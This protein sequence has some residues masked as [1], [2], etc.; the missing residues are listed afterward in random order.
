MNRLWKQAL[1]MPFMLRRLYYSFRLMFSSYFIGGAALAILLVIVTVFIEK[2]QFARATFDTVLLMHTIVLP[3]VT[4]I[5]TANAFAEELEERVFPLVW[6]YPVRKW[7]LFVERASSLLIILTLY[8]AASIFAVHMWLF[9]LTRAQVWDLLR[10]AIPTHV[11]LGGMTLMFSLIGRS[12]LTGL[13]AGG[14]Y[15]FVELITRGQWTK[16]SIFLFEPVWKLG[17]VD[18]IVNRWRVF[19]L[20]LLWFTV[21][22]V[23]FILGRRRLA[24]K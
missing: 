15:W 20:G 24:N 10:L 6:T 4:I 17:F 22:L 18:E 16:K 9:E 1:L 12:L 14:G 21:S 8:Y 13:A 23:L 11:F 7:A 3:L 19:G 2:W 5:F